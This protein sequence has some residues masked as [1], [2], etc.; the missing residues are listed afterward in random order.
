MRHSSDEKVA[1][2]CPEIDLILTGHD[3]DL[4]LRCVNGIP[5]LN[6]GHDFECFS[7]INIWKHDNAP[8]L[9]IDN[10]RAITE[11]DESGLKKLVYQGPRF[12]FEVTSYEVQESDP[13]DLEVDA[14]AKD[15]E[16]KSEC[17]VASRLVW[18]Q[19]PV[20]GSEFRS[21]EVSMANWMA[22]QLRKHEFISGTSDFAL[23][24][25]GNMRS[26]QTFPANG[27]CSEK[28]YGFTLGDLKTVITFSENTS[29]LLISTR[30]LVDMLNYSLSLCKTAG[31]GKLLHVS[32][33]R[34]V[35]EPRL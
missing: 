27:I 17:R 6:S 26:N 12:I 34:F 8:K 29:Q 14:I 2:L 10:D 1:K 11:D 33:L 32:G 31:D 3:H 30:T 25:G 20:D 7:N 19:E 22:D 23:V 35:F 18:L 28:N 24:T 15:I 21:K 9:S 5:I 16:E 13:V 4:K